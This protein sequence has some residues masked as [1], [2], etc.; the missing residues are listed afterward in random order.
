MEHIKRCI[1][2][3]DRNAKRLKQAAADKKKEARQRESRA[4]QK[5][6]EARLLLDEA[7]KAEQEAHLRDLAARM[8]TE[9]SDKRLRNAEVLRSLHKICT[10]LRLLGHRFREREEW[11][12][13][14]EEAW[15]L[16]R[17]AADLNASLKDRGLLTDLPKDTEPPSPRDIERIIQH[18]MHA[19][20]KKYVD[21][22][23]V[24][25]TY[26]SVAV[27]PDRR[28]VLSPDNGMAHGRRVAD[29]MRKSCSNLDKC[30]MRSWSFSFN[31]MCVHYHKKHLSALVTA[32]IDN[33]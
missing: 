31:G 16:Q 11:V 3:Q 29:V 18:K 5:Q 2:E 14:E 8:L 27:P 6:K 32:V 12:E 28:P 24:L 13:R 21:V 30:R 4:L 26:Y 10:A 17:K 15:R 19:W 20:E 7:D 23:Y 33:L 25:E 22:R 9:K 1:E